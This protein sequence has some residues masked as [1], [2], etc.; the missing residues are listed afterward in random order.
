MSFSGKLIVFTAPSGS[1]KT[2]I[3][4]HIL[5]AFPETA[6]SVSATTRMRRSYEVHGRDYYYLSVE[7]F[8]LWVENEAFAEWEEV[9][10]NQFY[11]TLRS[12]IERLHQLGKH[13]VFDVDVKGAMS[14][15][16]SFP[17]TTLAVF[18]KVPSM[19]ELEHR[20][21][22][23]GTETE[24]NIQKRLVKARQELAFEGEFDTTLLNDDLDKTLKEAESIVRKF[25]L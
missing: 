4:H 22:A 15:K 20:L 14:I 13:V 17:D 23:R 21:R 1:G 7:T 18:I 2:T 5:S 6:F 3:V 25:I 9:Y 24:A 16:S 12:E 10:P 19:E 8:K 11:G